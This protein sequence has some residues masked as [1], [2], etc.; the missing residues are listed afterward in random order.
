MKFSM[1]AP[2]LALL[3]T[4]P[5]ALATHG[6]GEKCTKAKYRNT[7]GC[8]DDDCSVV[9]TSLSTEMSERSLID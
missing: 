4:V 9:S 6:I 2:A 1:I 3:A 8:S 7:L 5:G